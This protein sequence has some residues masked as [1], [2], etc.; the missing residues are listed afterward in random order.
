M[1][2]VT[3]GCCEPEAAPTP[4]R[5][6]NRPGLSAI[7]YRIG[8]YSAFREA[9]LQEIAGT[10][11]LAALRTRL[12]DD[13]AITVLELWATVA[14]VLTFYQERIANEGYLR[15]ARLRDSVLRMA[16]LID[17][18]L[19]PGAAAT[20]L[21]AF[22]LEK[23]AR[24]KIPVGLRVQ[25]VPGQDEKPQKFETLEAITA[26]AR[27][28]RLRIVPAPVGINPLAKGTTHAWLVPGEA[29]LAMAEALAP[30]DRFLL[31]DAG[32]IEELKVEETRIEHDRVL[33]SW[34]G[35]IQGSSWDVTSGA[36]K[37]KRTFRL[38]GYNA[39]ATFM[40]PIDNP[41]VAGGIEWK[42]QKTVWVYSSV[43]TSHVMLDSLYEEIEVG[44]RL[45]VSN[46][47]TLNTL[48][49]VTAID[50]RRSTVG[51]L[52]DTVT[53]LTVFPDVPPVSDPKPVRIY[54]LA[55][56]PIRF[57]GYTYPE[58]LAPST[59]LVPGRWLDD[60]TIEVGRTIAKNSLRPGFAIAV[61]EIDRKRRV[62]LQDA[63][64]RLV[65]A[66]IN[67]VSLS[68][69]EVRFGPTA[70]DATTVSDLGLLPE[71]AEVLSGIASA[72]LDPFPILT[73]LAPRLSVT[74]GDVGPVTVA[75]SGPLPDLPAVASQLQA[76]LQAANPAPGF[77]G[78]RVRVVDDRL[79]VL[80]GVAGTAVA[81]APTGDDT[82]TAV[83]LGLD[84]NRASWVRG[85]ASGP[86]PAFSTAIAPNAEL[87]VS[88]AGIGPRTAV[89]P[90]AITDLQTAADAVQGA[91]NATDP[92]LA[93]SQ[94]RV[95]RLDDRLLVLPGIVGA[96]ME[97]YLRIDLDPESDV[98][99]DASSAVLLG[100][101]A[102]AS[103]GESVREE[104]LGDGDASATFQRFSLRKH[105]L[106]YVPSAEPAGMASSLRLLVDRVLWQGVPNLYG[107][108]PTAEVYTTRIADDGTI[109]VRFGDG[110]SGARPSSGRG[111]IT[112][113]YRHGLGLA[114]RV[115]GNTLTTLL[116]RPIGL[117]AVTNPRAA[118]G[119]ADPESLDEARAN[120]PTTVRTFGRAVSLLDFEDLAMATG[121]VAKARATWVWNGESRA[122]H[123]TLAGQEAAVFSPDTLSRL[124]AG[125]DAQRDPNHPLMLDNFVRV[126]LVIAATVHVANSYVA[127]DV[128]AAARSALL[129]ALSFEVL[130]FG[131]P[132]HLSDIYQVLQDV[133][134]VMW[135]KVTLLQ[136]KDRSPAFLASRGADDRPVQERLRI[137]P[138]RVIPGPPDTVMP[139]E[140]AWI[141]APTYD[142]T[143]ITS[144]GLPL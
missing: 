46:G 142:A 91:L 61:E 70:T 68:G 59:V 81:F 41:Q 38:F 20:T 37:F 101:V 10:S 72:A 95:L 143:L 139:A 102:R 47:G 130:R 64:H 6:D 135:V 75:L 13:H 141:E 26:D 44:S 34:S 48:V 54:E 22:T 115:R 43:P 15:T 9:M 100:N 132:L 67:A 29:A 35:A 25:S 119:G 125:L 124:H 12:S 87:L 56:P 30:G 90:V 17:Y 103:H 85:L 117:K 118:E 99:L 109:T 137:Y 144:G 96:E 140:Q 126:P 23:D 52:S 110:V 74:I 134:G 16:R 98:V 105:P 113:F 131:Q 89:L 58:A 51:P 14:D 62:L 120:A 111:N 97:E 116:D 78:A 82:T 83:E 36:F 18:Q 45:L 133:A 121:E 127:T 80:P 76:V 49:T 94:A 31:F 112:A 122:V 71:Q 60:E 28:N 27:L 69:G 106:T 136:F 53:R 129:E 42:L 108:A 138:A 40:L 66:E 63:Q 33:L 39:P 7:A 114:G 77:A 92:A 24:V 84:P 50:Q 32:A 2:L 57:W 8:T 123:L 86:L 107:Q 11:D 73:A 21:L 5:I 55:G 4:A 128:E 65:A 79:L 93:F 1:N 3:C 104:V 88:I 19:G